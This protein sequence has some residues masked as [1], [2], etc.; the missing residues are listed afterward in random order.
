ML[1][2]AVESYLEVRRAMGFALHSEGS[3]L[4]SF[5]KYSDASGQEPH[6]HRNCDS[7]GGRGAIGHHASAPTWSS[8]PTCAIPSSG[9]STS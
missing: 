8:N 7:V 4:Q 1:T 6:L 5:A 2:Q 9:G 3:L